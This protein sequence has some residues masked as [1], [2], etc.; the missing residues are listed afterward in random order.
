MEIEINIT[1]RDDGYKSD[2]DSSSFE[3]FTEYKKI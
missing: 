2:I 3:S 1:T